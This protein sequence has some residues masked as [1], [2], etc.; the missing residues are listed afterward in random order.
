MHREACTHRSFY[1]ETGKLSHRDREAFTHSKLLRRASGPLH[2]NLLH[3]YREAFTRS[4]LLHTEA[5]AHRSF[6]TEKLLHKEAFTKRSFYTQQAFT[7][8]KR[9]HKRS[10]Y[11]ESLCTE[12]LFAHRKLLHTEALQR[13][14][15]THRSLYTE[16]PLH[17]EAFTH[18]SFYIHTASFHTEKPLHRDTS[19]FAQWCPKLQLENWMDLGA[20]AKKDDFEAIFKG[21]LRGKSSAPKLRKSADKSL[22]QP[23]ATLML[24]L[25]AD[26]RCPDCKRQKYYARS[27]GAKQP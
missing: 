26:L 2:R 24:P 1:T 3:R 11:T 5:F 22:S 25:R 27:H 14:D 8:S 9:S 4:E 20:R 17:R 12:K 10:H 15:F 7:R 18:R 19:L 21:I 23:V 16:K 6:Y 13:E